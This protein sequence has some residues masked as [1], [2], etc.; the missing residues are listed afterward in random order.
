M[1]LY[2]LMYQDVLFC[3]VTLY[4]CSVKTSLTK[5]KF[6]IDVNIFPSLHPQTLYR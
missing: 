4:F 1:L 2:L 6:V 3:C 5:L